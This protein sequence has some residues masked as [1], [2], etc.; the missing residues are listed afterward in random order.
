MENS[1]DLKITEVIPNAIISKRLSYWKVRHNLTNDEL[2]VIKKIIAKDPS[3]HFAHLDDSYC[4][5]IKDLRKRKIKATNFTG[6]KFIW[7]F[8]SY[9]FIRHLKQQNYIEKLEKLS[10]RMN[11]L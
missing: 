8:K 6:H 4:S 11:L 3:R 9:S 2:D 1:A 10:L 7:L 5:L